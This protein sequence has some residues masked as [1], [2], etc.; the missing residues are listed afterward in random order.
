MV[1]SRSRSVKFV[2]VSNVVPPTARRRVPANTV[3]RQIDKIA[4]SEPFVRS[5]RLIRFL[6]LVVDS[7]LARKTSGLKEYVIGVNVFDRPGSFDPRLDPIVRVEAG[8][9]RAKLREYYDTEGLADPVRITLPKQTY[10][11]EIEF[12]LET[13]LQ[14][15]RAP[16]IAVLPLVD[17]SPR[18]SQEYLC[19][20]ISEA[21]IDGLVKLKGLRVVARTSS[22]QYKGKAM[23]IR[24]IG[25]ELKADMIVAG[26][27]R[28]A[29]DRIRVSAR[30]SSASN[31]YHLR[32]VTLDRQYRDA[33]SVQDEISEAVV[34]SV[35]NELGGR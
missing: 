13:S 8:R 17:L 15:G 26:S 31:G 2:T 22:F 32:S 21:I 20:G 23:D 4:R 6:R 33:F 19:D 30:L 7:K 12:A 18:R 27:V 25:R 1:P 5:R 3:R 11:P 35:K 10:A 34:R 24:D 29:G 14:P 9:L 16:S 28:K